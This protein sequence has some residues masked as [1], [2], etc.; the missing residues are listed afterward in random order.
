[1]SD[2]LLNFRPTGRKTESQ[3]VNFDLYNY[4]SDL[5]LKPLVSH[6]TARSSE[7]EY[8]PGEELSLDK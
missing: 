3:F 7:D 1:M 8:C 4:Q 5:N 2:S 6:N